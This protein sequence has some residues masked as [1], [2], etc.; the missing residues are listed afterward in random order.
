MDAK[1]GRKVGHV[2]FEAG[3]ENVIPPRT[4]RPIALPGIPADAVKA[5]RAYTLRQL[6]ILRGKHAA[7]PRADVLRGIKA[8]TSHG[9][10]STQL[11]NKVR[12][13][14]SMRG[15]FDYR[16][17]K[18]GGG[19]VNLGHVAWMACVMYG[20][21]GPNPLV[22]LLYVQTLI[23]RIPPA[24]CLNEGDEF[25]RIE[26]VSVRIDVDEDRLSALMDDH[27]RSSSKSQRTGNNY[28]SR[29]HTDCGHRQV[30]G[31]STRTDRHRLARADIVGKFFFK[32]LGAR[33]GCDPV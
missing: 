31:S 2:V 11:G 26:V 24:L 1:S 13:A 30:Q 14:E 9:V 17:A 32:R 18:R 29:A 4:V 16:Q 3:V 6:W 33:P 15:I 22:S 20:N 25:V 28:I 12:G 10:K 19:G 5:Q 8:E 21:D 23:T 27:I 7:F